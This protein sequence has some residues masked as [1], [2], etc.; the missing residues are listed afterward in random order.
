VGHGWLRDDAERELAPALLDALRNGRRLQ[1]PMRDYL[2]FEGPLDAAPEFGW[3]LA[4]K[5]FIPES[6]N[7]F[8]PQDHAWCVATEIDLPFTLA[9]GSN[10]LA[11]HLVGHSRLETEQAF[12]DD[13]VTADS[14]NQNR[15]GP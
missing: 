1:F 10:A 9:A 14:D 8:W 7:L 3:T 12:A 4:G 11:E 15:D 13:P 6:P 5:R 2:L